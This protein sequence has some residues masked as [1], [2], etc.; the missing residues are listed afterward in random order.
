[1]PSSEPDIR[2][3]LSGLNEVENTA[4]LCPINWRTSEPELCVCVCVCVGGCMC[5]QVRVCVYV[6]VD[7][8]CIW[9][10]CSMYGMCM[11]VWGTC[12][13]LLTHH[14]YKYVQP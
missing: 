3:E 11:C 10:A 4:P 14:M 13:W 9:Y 8:F 7:Y 2:N 5:V 12:S 1:M 6:W